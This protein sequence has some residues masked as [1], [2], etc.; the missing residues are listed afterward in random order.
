VEAQKVLIGSVTTGSSGLT[1]DTTRAVEFMGELLAENRQA[2]EHKGSITDTRGTVEKLYRTEGG[3]LVV[4]VE[5]WSRWQGEPTEYEL[6]QVSET[7]LGPSGWYWQLGQEAGY[8]RPLTLE[9]A[10][11]PE[12]PEPVEPPTWA[13]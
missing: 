6:H 10:L 5:R 7:D 13:E 12:Q 2:G 8:G 11:S 3:T 1:Q 4:A 9:E